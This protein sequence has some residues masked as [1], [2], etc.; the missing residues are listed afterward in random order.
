MLFQKV[1]R[2]PASLCLMIPEKW[3]HVLE[4]CVIFETR[5]QFV[6]NNVN[7]TETKVHVCVFLGIVQW[8]M[9]L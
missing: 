9:F 3:Q 4:V 2:V 8:T 6:V 1:A 5:L 7:V